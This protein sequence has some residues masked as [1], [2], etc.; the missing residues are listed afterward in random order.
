MRT[1]C[2]ILAITT[3]LAGCA[4]PS[5]LTFQ[6]I[7]IQPTFSMTDPSVSGD[8]YHRDDRIIAQFR[9]DQGVC[10]FRIQNIS[11]RPVELL[12]DKATLSIDHRAHPVRMYDSYYAEV[13]VVRAVSLP[14]LGHQTDLVIP[15]D[16]VL[17][18]DG[19]WYEVSLLPVREDDEQSLGIGG[20]IANHLLS[21]TLPVADGE[22]EITY[23][24]DFVNEGYERGADDLPLGRPPVPTGRRASIYD[25][26]PLI[27]AVAGFGILLVVIFQTDKSS[28]I[29]E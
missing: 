4:A 28:P 14:P 8:L 21:L 5:A 9:I 19:T 22:N 16:H 17:Y 7:D 25:Q 10:F 3:C 11:P 20:S 12:W 6:Q 15:A 27:G 29:P 2:A 13:P 26:L 18:Q 23:R 24:F 1:L